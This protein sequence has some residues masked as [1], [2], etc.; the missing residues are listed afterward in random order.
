M[1]DVLSAVSH[2]TD[3]GQPL[4][5][6]DLLA[7]PAADVRRAFESGTIQKRAM[8]FG[9]ATET[10]ILPASLPA[11]EDLDDDSWTKEELAYLELA[12]CG[13]VSFT[14]MSEA[15]KRSGGQILQQAWT[16]K[17]VRRSNPYMD[18]WSTEVP[19]WKIARL[20]QFLEE[21][22]RRGCDPTDGGEDLKH[23]A[24]KRCFEAGR[25]SDVL[26][27]HCHHWTGAEIERLRSWRT[28]GRRV[29]SIA[30]DLGRTDSAVATK[31]TELDLA[32]DQTWTEDEDRVVMSGIERGLANRETAAMLPLR[33]E[34]AVKQRAVRLVGPRA[35][36]AWT[37][38]ERNGLAETVKAGGNMRD[39]CISIGRPPGSAGW[40]M[41]QIGLT[42]PASTLIKKFQPFEDKRIIEGWKRKEKP[43]DI[44]QELGRSLPSVY[45][46][47][48]T[49]K[50]TGKGPGHYHRWWRKFEIDYI[51]VRVAQGWTGAEIAAKLRR[52]KL[53]VYR[54]A[55]LNGI[56]WSQRSPRKR[57]AS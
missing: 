53:A 23:R 22:F 11:A 47:A 56:K 33:S 45:N 25:N 42:H 34:L 12:Y 29:S 5:A 48:F 40:Q 3:R 50:I 28:E 54:V 46:R 6:K 27:R 39:Y 1:T 35:P 8:R 18:P 7:Y 17:M 57:A 44:A 9:T 21:A 38:E 31:I 55:A 13:G 15:L 52:S 4:R 2:A 14:R 20:R 16:L 43:R 30:R 49:L 37:E 32:T 10:V 51:R 26:G 36:T 24:L 41:K 19:A